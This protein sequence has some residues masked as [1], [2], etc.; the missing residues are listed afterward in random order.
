[1]VLAE[2]D[3]TSSGRRG[4]GRGEAAAVER[5]QPPLQAL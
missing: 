3:A 2:W 5:K 4:M 1:M